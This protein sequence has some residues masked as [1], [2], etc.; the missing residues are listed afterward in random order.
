MSIRF[1]LLAGLVWVAVGCATTLERDRAFSDSWAY[2]RSTEG[3]RWEPGGE[4][5]LSGKEGRG[6]KAAVRMDEEGKPRLWLGGKSRVSAD[7]DLNG[8]DP[9]VGVKYKIGW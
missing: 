5:V 8:G 1:A 3:E 9:E 7:F 6:P 2:Q 4:V